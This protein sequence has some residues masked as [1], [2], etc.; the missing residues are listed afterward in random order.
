MIFYFVFK[1]QINPLEEDK[2]HVK[3]NQKS[4]N[5]KSKIS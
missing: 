5:Q 4:Q 2:L 3:K 1:S